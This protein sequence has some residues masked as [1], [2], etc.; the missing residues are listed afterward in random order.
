ME[1]GKNAERVEKGKHTD[2]YSIVCAYLQW[3]SEHG[4]A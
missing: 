2:S 1:R 3:L 4:Q